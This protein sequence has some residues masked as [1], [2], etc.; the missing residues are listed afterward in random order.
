MWSAVGQHCTSPKAF[1]K[2]KGIHRNHIGISY[3]KQNEKRVARL[4]KS[5]KAEGTQAL[6]YTLPAVGGWLK[7]SA[8]EE[9]PALQVQGGSTPSKGR[10]AR[11]IDC[12]ERIIVFNSFCDLLFSC[13]HRTARTAARTY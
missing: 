12:R 7:T 1:K 13:C 4:K 11:S 9:G 3:I 6:C 2:E 5:K 8:S 10:W